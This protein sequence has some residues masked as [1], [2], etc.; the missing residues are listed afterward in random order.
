FQSISAVFL[1]SLIACS[2]AYKTPDLGGLYNSLVQNESPYRNPVILIPGLLGSKL[3]DKSTGT[4]VWGTF[5][6]NT[7]SPRT[8]EGARIIALPMLSKETLDEMRDNVVPAGTLDRVRLNFLGYPLGQNTYA[9]ILSILG[10]GGYRDQSLAEAGVINYGVESA[11][12]LDAFIKEKKKYVQLEIEKRFGIKDYDV[13]FDIVA[14][15]MGGLVARYYLRYGSE[16]I[17]S[18]GRIPEITWAGSRHVEN[19][20]M[21]GTPNAGSIDMLVSLVEGFSP[22]IFLPEYPPAVLGTMPSLYEL[23]PR[24]RHNPVL[25]ENKLPIKD[26]LDPELWIQKG[27]GLAN[28]EQDRVLRSLL[29]NIDS[30]EKRRKIA[31]VYLRKVLNR[32]RQFTTVMD[33]PAKPP[34]SL[35]MLLV[36]GDSEKTSKTVQYNKNGELNVIETGPGD[37]TVLRSSALGDERL[38]DTQSSRLISPIQWSQVLFLFSNHLDLTKH[39]AFTDNLLYFLLESQK[40]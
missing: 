32:A 30:P 36:A 7:V 13:K 14:H 19:L 22:A 18:N 10:I 27:W 1:L 9:H 12:N 34:L 37:G 40:N 16:D 21:I 17:P 26:I 28:P 29:P 3:V 5:G 15:S 24:S 6:L 4:V 23:L 38:I 11:K 20:V 2:P 25:D 8:A 33:M 31:I 35:R 39:P